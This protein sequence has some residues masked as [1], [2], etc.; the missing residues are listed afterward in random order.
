VSEVVIVR[1]RD[2]KKDPPNHDRPVWTEHGQM[3]FTMEHDDFTPPAR[4]ERRWV[5]LIGQSP[6]RP[7]MQPRWWYDLRPTEGEGLTLSGLRGLAA[8]LKLCDL[9]D[10]PITAA[11]L[12]RLQAALDAI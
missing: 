1:K 2:A 10:A 11:D 8:V 6:V 12:A 3:A 5:W 9:E 4:Y 7:V